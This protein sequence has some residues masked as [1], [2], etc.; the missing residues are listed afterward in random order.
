MEIGWAIGLKY[1]AG[2]TKLTPSV[3][4]AVGILGS[5]WLVARSARDIPIGTAYGVFVGIG[6]GGTGLLGIFLFNESAGAL[7]LLSLAA[8]VLGVVGLKLFGDPDSAEAS[9]AA[10]SR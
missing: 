6:A 8:I 2:F 7:R 4:V 5:F 1:T 10:T 9:I 3:L